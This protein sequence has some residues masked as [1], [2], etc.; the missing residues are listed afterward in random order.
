[1]STSSTDQAVTS[2]LHGDVMRMLGIFL[3]MLI[4]ITSCS[5][6]PELEVSLLDIRLTSPD[7]EWDYYFKNRGLDFQQLTKDVQQLEVDFEI[8]NRYQKD[9][10]LFG[11][12]S[13]RLNS[14]ALGIRGINYDFPQRLLAGETKK[15]TIYYLNYYSFAEMIGYG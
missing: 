2:L 11:V 5:R 9:I 15:F 4:F 13:K 10:L 6:T 14:L 1:M 12:Y 8:S 7:N 3:I